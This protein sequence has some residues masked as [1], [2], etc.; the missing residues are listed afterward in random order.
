MVKNEVGEN[1]DL[2]ITTY[3]LTSEKHSFGIHMDTSPKI[4]THEEQ[5]FLYRAGLLFNI[6]V[7][8]PFF[9]S[10]NI[11]K[12]AV[13]PFSVHLVA[14]VGRYHWPIRGLYYFDWQPTSSHSSLSAPVT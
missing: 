12:K 3:F 10:K 5:I 8:V 2:N 1:N 13:F 14:R 9:K 11:V 7:T 6:D 4:C